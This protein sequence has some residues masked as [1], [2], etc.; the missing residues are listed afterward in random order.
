MLAVVGA[1]WASSGVSAA[2]ATHAEL[3]P[4]LVTMRFEDLQ[5]VVSAGVKR[6]RFSNTVGNRGPGALELFPVKEDCDGDGV[7]SDDRAAYQRPF[8]DTDDDG[9]FDRDV[10]A[11]GAPVAVGCFFFHGEHDHWHLEDF[12]RYEL[13]VR[14]STGERVALARKVS[15][16]VRDSLAAFDVPGQPATVYYGDCHRS[17]TTGMSVGW[18][19]IYQGSLPGQSLNVTGLPD[20]RYCLVSTADPHGRL[21]ETDQTDNVQTLRLRLHGNSVS[22]AGLAC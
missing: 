18:A 12:A 15:F 2:G 11:P 21:S 14:V 16:C 22:T 17:S 13:R 6:L 1:L 10:D 19:D 5:V 4:N 7:Y 3:L 20:G 8:I 9:V